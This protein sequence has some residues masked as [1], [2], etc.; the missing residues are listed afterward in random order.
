MLQLLEVSAELG[1]LAELL[2][3]LG[4]VRVAEPVL[5]E[6]PEQWTKEQD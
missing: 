2:A 1:W 5:S 3:A 4:P 6:A